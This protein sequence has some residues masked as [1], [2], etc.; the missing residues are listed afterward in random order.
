MLCFRQ[1]NS[2]TGLKHK[3]Y[4]KEILGIEILGNKK[5]SNINIFRITDYKL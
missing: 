4:R 1:V 3:L 5:V 2:Q